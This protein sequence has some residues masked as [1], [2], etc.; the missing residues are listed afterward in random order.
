M[1]HL[2]SSDEIERLFEAGQLTAAVHERVA[3]LIEPGVSTWELDQEAESFIRSRGAIPAFKGYRGYPGT[4]CASINEEVV[5]G[6]PSKKRVLKEGDL[7][8]IDLGVI[9]DGWFGDA[10]RSHTVGTVSE[11]T[12]TLNR[13]T[14]ESL[15]KAIDTMV[16]GNRLGDLGHA[17]QSHVE[18]HGFSVV[19]DFVGHGIGRSLHEDPQIP[20][21]GKAGRGKRFEE[22]M[23]LA[24][25]PMINE[26]TYD[27]IVLEDG[28]TAITA[29]RKMSA[30]WEHTIAITKDGPRILTESRP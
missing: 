24:I 1:I 28:W 8:G 2:K 26:G 7:I 12:A 17:V 16:P 11:T 19:R 3:A 25:E 22:G 13:V 27:V 4:L 20:N 29:D 18:A 30:H 15:Y 23:V 21:Y 10:A 6:I 5:H 14:R 9:I